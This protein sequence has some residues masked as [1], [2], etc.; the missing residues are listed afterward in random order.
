MLPSTSPYI[1]MHR[2]LFLLLL[3]LCYQLR[4]RIE[5]DGRFLL[6]SSPSSFAFVTQPRSN[7]HH[8]KTIRWLEPH[9]SLQDV[10]E[11]HEN[12]DNDTINI[13]VDV[14]INSTTNS[15]N[16]NRVL[17]DDLI[18]TTTTTTSQMSNDKFW[19]NIGSVLTTESC[20]LLGIKSLGVDYGLSR[21]GLAMTVGYE[22]IPLGIITSHNVT[23]VCHTIVKYASTHQVQQIIVGL[24]LHKNGTIA[25]QTMI[26]YNFTQQLVMMVVSYLGPNIKVLLFDERYTSKMAAAREHTKNPSSLLYGT[27]DATAACIILENYYDDHGVGAHL[28]TLPNNEDNNGIYEQCIQQY[29]ER[30]S[31]IEQQ[32][33]QQI[34]DESNKRQRRL[35]IIAQSKLLDQQQKQQQNNTNNDTIKKRKRKKK[36]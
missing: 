30:Q 7:S 13:V 5:V 28:V 19:I 24:P 31:M 35:E 21:T 25:E 11:L 32:R 34:K 2:V 1:F 6:S 15:S 14:T 29:N 8:S 9:Q 23:E 10:Q 4:S 3:L 33:I 36:K 17:L 27:L 26:T 20:P 12:R 18:S 16:N 22:P